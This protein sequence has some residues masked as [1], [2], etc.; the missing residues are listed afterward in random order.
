[1]SHVAIDPK[2][3]GMEVFHEVLKR[4]KA[5]ADY[6]HDVIDPT[7][8][9]DTVYD[10]VAT[11]DECLKAFKIRLS[12]TAQGDRQ[13]HLGEISQSTQ[14]NIG[15]IAPDIP[16]RFQSSQPRPAWRR[17]KTANLGKLGFAQL[18]MLLQRT[19]NSDVCGIKGKSLHSVSSFMVKCVAKVCMTS[20]HTNVYLPESR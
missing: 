1:M 16:T 18:T 2:I 13:N 4:S 15:V 5:R 6:L 20:S 10:F 19:E 7:T 11:V 12:M 8:R 9:C 14:L 3:F 17:R